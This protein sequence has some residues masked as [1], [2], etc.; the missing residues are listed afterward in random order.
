MDLHNQLEFTISKNTKN[1]VKIYCN[2][3]QAI[4]ELFKPEGSFRPTTALF[5]FT[6][7]GRFK[8]K[9]KGFDGSYLVTSDSDFKS[10]WGL[11]LE[12]L[13]AFLRNSNI[14]EQII[15]C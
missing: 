6:G 11:S 15:K 3:L 12:E 2:N 9:E 1:F 14:P 5:Y 7:H 8:P 4:V 13:R 10:N